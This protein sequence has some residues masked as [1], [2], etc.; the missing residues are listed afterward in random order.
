M[1]YARRDVGTSSEAT[2]MKVCPEDDE[3]KSRH[4]SVVRAESEQRLLV[5]A[6]RDFASIHC[7]PA[8]QFWALPLVEQ[9]VTAAKLVR[10]ELLGREVHLHYI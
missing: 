5:A 2:T 4:Y 3:S 6:S 7:R 1:S 9:Q 10:L 8:D